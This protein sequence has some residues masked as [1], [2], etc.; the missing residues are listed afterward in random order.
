M[1]AMRT[2]KLITAR[3]PPETKVKFQDL[4]AMY[5]LNESRFMRS[6]IDRAVEVVREPE[7]ESS[8]KIH[9]E[10]RAERLYVRLYS[11]DRQLLAERAATRGVPS[12]TYLAVLTRSHLRNLSPLPEAE[13]KAFFSSVQG[14][15]RLPRASYWESYC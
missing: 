8:R 13:R 3:V 2:T 14:H 10:T 7:P 4:A 9:E 15:F 5:G 1:V 11:D 6:L 12:A